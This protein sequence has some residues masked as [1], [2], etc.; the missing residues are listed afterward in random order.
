[1]RTSDLYGR[2]VVV[3]GAATEGRAA[4]ERLRGR[5]ELRVVVDGAPAA[6]EIGG[7]VVEPVGGDVLAWADVVVRS[8][9]VPRYS[10]ELTNSVSVE[11]TTLVALWLADHVDDCVVGVTG[12]KGKSTTATLVSA[13]LNASG[14]RAEL[15]GNIGRPVYELDTMA[16]VEAYVI[17]VSSYQA[18]DVTCS[19]RYGVLTNLAA[20]HLNWHGN[21]ERYRADKLNLFAHGTRHL[22]V[23]GL[24]AVSRVEV[25]AAWPVT[26]YATEGYI[27]D[28]GVVRLD[29]RQVVDTTGSALAAHHLALDLCGALTATRLVLG[30]PVAPVVADAVVRAYRALPG[31]MESVAADASIEFVDDVLATNPLAVEAALDSFADRPVVILLGGADRGVDLTAIADRIAAHPTPLTAVLLS[32]TTT[33]WEAL[34]DGRGVATLAVE[35]DDVADAVVAATAIAPAGAVV[36]FAPCAPTPAALGNYL[37]RSRL[38]REAARAVVA[39]RAAATAP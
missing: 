2:R 7:V 22:A 35:G 13:L 10:P 12:T 39:Q 8:A 33:R 25:S 1:M 15:A 21:V 6:G 24:D 30:R 26:W 27:V 34:L 18:V 36:L 31:R 29:G 20:D 4:V 28:D 38:F 16:G 3:W 5:A 14:C 17:E 37:D 11:V 32:E 23:N 19:P 9:G